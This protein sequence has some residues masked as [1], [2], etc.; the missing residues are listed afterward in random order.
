MLNPG[1]VMTL[2]G[3]EWEYYE[4]LREVAPSNWKITYAYGDLQVVAPTRLHER[5]KCRLGGLIERALEELDIKLWEDGST[6][7]KIP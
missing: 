3:V 5:H 6:T 4:Y 7:L 1:Q 2:S